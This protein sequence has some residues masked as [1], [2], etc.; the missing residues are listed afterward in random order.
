MPQRAHAAES[1]RRSAPA[2]GV[3]GSAPRATPLTLVSGAIA[4]DDLDRVTATVAIA[5]G[6]PIAVAI[7]ALGAPF[8]RPAGALSPELSDAVH[9]QATACVAGVRVTAPDGVEQPVAIQIGEQVV[10]IVTAGSARNGSA[11]EIGPA[12]LRAWL[13]AAAAAASINALIR[14]AQGGTRAHDG[15]ALLH[16]LTAGV[17]DD[18]AGFLARCRRAGCELSTGATALAARVMSCD[19]RVGGR[20]GDTPAPVLADMVARMVDDDG[21]LAAVTGPGRLLAL[22]PAGARCD[23]D[24]LAVRLRAWGLDVAVS[25]PRRDPDE[26]VQL[27]ERTVS[28]LSDYDARHDTDLLATLRAFLA[29]DGST[30]E[31]AEAMTLH[32]HTV[33]YRLS[34]V[35]AVSGL[36]PYESDG[37]ERLSLGLK[38]DQIIEADARARA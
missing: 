1:N 28:P 18:L 13:E 25:A 29:H 34:R 33:G 7:P 8:V 20:A 26:L 14:E 36:S 6:R 4:G 30:T 19:A 10:G 11:T 35:H 31:T 24:A 17:P 32:R 21:V 27:R 22:V 23:P 12:E 15:A 5:L 9:L 3:E 37:R 16:E 2:R 38:A